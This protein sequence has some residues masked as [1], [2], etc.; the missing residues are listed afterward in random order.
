MSEFG[1]EVERAIRFLDR[2]ESKTLTANR[3]AL[4]TTARRARTEAARNIREQVAL[5]ATYVNQRLTVKPATNGKLEAEVSAPRRGMLL[6]RFKWK[7]LWT[8]RKGS[9]GRRPAG[10]TGVIKPGRSYTVRRFFALPLRA[11]RV[12][13][14][15]GL[16]L[17]MRLGP[18]RDNYEVLHGPSLSQ[19][20]Q[21]V[22]TDIEPGVRERFHAEV[23][24]QLERLYGHA[25]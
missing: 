6:S 25:G 10:I 16:G 19:V 5:A 21:S 20:Y 2:V 1:K 7:Q 13:G 14:G 8:G 12:D 22:R 15:N 3:M 9:K 23:V 11:G 17:A 18:G 24:R 4:N